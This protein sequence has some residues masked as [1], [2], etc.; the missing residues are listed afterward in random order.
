MEK[1]QLQEVGL[2]QCQYKETDNLFVVEQ[3]L[4]MSGSSLQDIVFM[5][6]MKM[7]AIFIT[8][9]KYLVHEQALYEFL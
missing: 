8:F 1:N 2:T 9:G 5:V 6:M 7:E 4:I 3:L